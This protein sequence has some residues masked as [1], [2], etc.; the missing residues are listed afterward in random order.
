[1]SAPMPVAVDVETLG[2]DGVLPVPWRPPAE[3]FCVATVTPERRE[4]FFAHDR[5]TIQRRLSLPGPKV[6]HN[7]AYDL[8]WLLA[9]GFTIAGPI[10]DTMWALSFD[11]G[12]AVKGLKAQPNGDAYPTYLPATSALFPEHVLDYCAHDAAATLALYLKGS[13][14]YTHRL[15]QLYSRLAPRIAQIS[16]RGLPLFADR[17]DVLWRETTVTHTALERELIAIAPI[18]WTST[19]QVARVLALQRTDD[20]AL[21]TCTHPAVP[22]LRAFRKA[23]KLLSAFLDKFRPLECLHGLMM[24][25]GSRI[26]RTSSS[27]E[28]LQQ[29]PRDPAVRRLFG[30]PDYAWLKLD[31]AQAELVVAAVLADCRPLLNAFRTGRDPHVET[32]SRIFRIAPDAV[33]KAQRMLG[34][35]LN[36][37]LLYGAGEGKVLEQAILTGIPM[38]LAQAAAFR[39]Q[40]LRAYPELQR[41]QDDIRRRLW[42][43]E[44]ITSAF[45]RRWKIDPEAPR[46][47]NQAL[48]APVASTAS[49][50]LLFGLNAV[51]DRLEA[52]GTVINLIHDEV[53]VLIPTG[54]WSDLAPTVREIAQT[55]AEIDPRFPMRVEVAV[56]PDWGA[57]VEQFTV[58]AS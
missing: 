41:W 28:N 44:P 33:T 19:Q 25:G 52:I 31:F 42:Q 45:G 34:K 56:G 38:T 55:M 54:S 9:A 24:L 46:S 30:A 11:N 50:L 8:V 1:M 58:G 39:D 4:A 27:N 7:S 48:Q 47:W 23:D 26:G 40:W 18:N 15:Y 43:G 49:D 53:D 17:V 2:A 6:L 16:L 57:T 10:V 37:A 14:W 22:R 36:F 12:V 21:A 5:R 35:L 13:P 3:L 32:A 20:A 29:I 51:W